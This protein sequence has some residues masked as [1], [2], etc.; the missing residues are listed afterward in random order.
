MMAKLYSYTYVSLD[1]VMSSPE[2]WTSSFW[3]NE[4]GEDLAE[5]LRKA[6]AMVLGRKTYEE[7]AEFWPRQGSD[8]P[9]ADLNNQ[10]RK[11]VVSRTLT[12]PT[13]S[14][15]VAVSMEALAERHF[16]GDLHITGSQQLVRSLLS[17]KMLDEMVLVI[18]P[19]VLG[20]GRRL[21]DGAPMTKL[22][23]IDIASFPN[24][25]TRLTLKSP[26]A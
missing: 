10:V 22:D 23:R 20:T 11:L 4:L 24:G 5:R 1:G 19:V 15:S 7:F 8:V 12:R 16:D 26:T 18:F 21:F 13:W 3:S 14:N 2:Q 25:V 9:F 6:A 17:L